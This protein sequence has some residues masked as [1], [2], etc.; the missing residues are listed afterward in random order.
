MKK[1]EYTDGDFNM[2]LFFSKQTIKFWRKSM[3]KDGHDS[4][5]AKETSDIEEIKDDVSQEP[6]L[7]CHNE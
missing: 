4:L 6:F 1:D 3:Q 7:Q 5:C 2:R